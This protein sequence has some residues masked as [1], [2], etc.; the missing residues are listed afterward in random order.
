MTDLNITLLKETSN[1]KPKYFLNEIEIYL[2]E[3]Y[4]TLKI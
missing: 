4:K 2:L 3:K 1:N